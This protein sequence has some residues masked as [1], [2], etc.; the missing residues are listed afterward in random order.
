MPASN[1]DDYIAGFPEDRQTVLCE[2]LR[3]IRS[4]APGA[5]EAIR[6]GM[7]AFRLGNGHPV[8]FA[9]WKLHL[10]LHDVPMLDEPLEAEIGPFRSGK[11]TLK[12]PFSKPIPFGLIERAVAQIANRGKAG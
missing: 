5:D 4:A 8:Y 2:V 11:D 10:S 1:I 7:P 12:F 3:R 9:G 6:Y